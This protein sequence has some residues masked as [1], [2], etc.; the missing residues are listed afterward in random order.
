MR[1]ETHAAE[2]ARICGAEHWRKRSFPGSPRSLHGDL[3]QVFCEVQA[4]NMQVEIPDGLEV[5]TCRGAE[6]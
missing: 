2:V 6:S 4:V 5:I 1:E 3:P